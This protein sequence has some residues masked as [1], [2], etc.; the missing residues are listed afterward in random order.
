MRH[1]TEPETGGYGGPQLQLESKEETFPVRAD[2]GLLVAG[3]KREAMTVALAARLLGKSRDTLYR[4]L[5]EGRLAGRK[6]GG[7]WIV[8]R[9]AVE[10]EWRAGL[11][12]RRR[13][14]ENDD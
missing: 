3:E 6:V 14:S 9:D 1:E 12:E 5:N 13:E 10:A 7:R 8:Y 4:W 2:L 11:V